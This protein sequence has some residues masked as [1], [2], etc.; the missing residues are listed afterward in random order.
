MQKTIRSL[1]AVAALLPATLW[2]QNTGAVFG[3]VVNDGH[4]SAQYRATYDV[5]S[6][7]LA[8]RFHY[9]RS[10]SGDL[11]WRVIGQLR[12]NAESDTDEDFLQAELFWQLTPDGNPWQRGLRFDVR[13]RSEGRPAQVGFNWTNQYSF[14]AKWSSR[15]LL[16]TTVQF[17][18]GATDGLFLQSRASLQY[19]IDA[20]RA[21]GLEMYSSYS[22]LDDIPS[23]E[24]QGHQL[25]PYLSQKLTPHY[26]LYAGALFR[27]N[28]SSPDSQLRFWI[29]KS[30]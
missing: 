30:L 18:E 16:L 1:A 24:Q 7:G 6:H 21:T 11:M 14:N 5:D 9:Q 4:E 17:G 2:A 12:K 13:Y 20:S 10:L 3:P 28:K 19:K 15:G 23:Y 27:L 8:Q 29:T 25:G 22:R 26:S